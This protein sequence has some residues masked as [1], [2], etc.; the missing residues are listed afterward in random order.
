MALH[1]KNF[2]GPKNFSTKKYPSKSHN[3]SHEQLEK[4][5]ATFGLGRTL[6]ITPAFP[7]PIRMGRFPRPRGEERAP[8]PRTKARGHVHERAHHGPTD[9]SSGVGR[10]TGISQRSPFPSRFATSPGPNLSQPSPFPRRFATS[11]GPALRQRSRGRPGVIPPS[12]FGRG[13]SSTFRSRRRRPLKRR[14]GR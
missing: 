8:A 9:R 2:P 5:V 12:P 1:K 6:P 3:P 7:G 10:R 13:V 11:P 4:R 14:R